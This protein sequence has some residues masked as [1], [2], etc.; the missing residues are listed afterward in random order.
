MFVINSV[1][2]KEVCK[3]AVSAVIFKR[4]MYSVAALWSG[5]SNQLQ[6]A[7]HRI[8]LPCSLASHSLINFFRTQ[9]KNIGEMSSPCLTSVLIL[10]GSEMSPKKFISDFIH[11]QI[12]LT[13]ARVFTGRVTARVSNS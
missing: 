10:I 8:P 3:S 9:L 12:C 1:F 4:S 7:R 5:F 13:T 6:K 2:S 11:I